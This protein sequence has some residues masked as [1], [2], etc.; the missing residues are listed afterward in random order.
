MAMIY[1]VILDELNDKESVSLIDLSEMLPELLL[2][3]GKHAHIELPKDDI[4]IRSTRK[5]DP[6]KQIEWV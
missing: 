2:K 1:R 5:I 6:S 3:Y 4:M